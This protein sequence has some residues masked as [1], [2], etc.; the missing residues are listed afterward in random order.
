M[1]L[2]HTPRLTNRLGYTLNVTF[3]TLLHIPY[4]ITDDSEYFAKYEGPKMA[5]GTTPIGDAPFLRA[6]SLLFETSVSRFDIKCITHLDTKALF[7]IDPPSLLPYD[8]LAAIFFMLSRYEEYLPFQPDQHGRFPASQ[9]VAYQHQ[10]LHTA[11]V[12]RWALQ[13]HKALLLHFPDLPSPSRHAEFPITIDVDAAYCYRHKGLI[14]TLRGFTLDLLLRRSR[15]NFMHRLRVLLNK[16]N[17]PYDNFDYILAQTRQHLSTPAVFFILLGDYSNFDKPIAFTN[18]SFR[19]LIQY[20]GD[21]AKMAI[22]PSYYA[23]EQ[24]ELIAKETQ[25]LSNI[26]HRTIVRSRFHFLR[27]SLPNSYQNLIDNNILHD[28][29]MGYPND[30]GYRAG[31]G[32]PYPFFDLSTNQEQQLT[33]HPFIA[34]DTTLNTHMHLSSDEAEQYLNQLIH[35][36]ILNQGTLSTLWHNQNLSDSDQWAGWRSIFEHLLLSAEQAKNT[37]F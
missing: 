26:L 4:L 34:M 8:P 22:H 12:D 1:L 21:N 17:D 9:S 33:I 31:T 10:F 24:P 28:Y 6:A 11:V 27:F 13:L 36:N 3:K 7:P 15:A 23:L 30:I 18:R 29:S 37:S 14:R 19:Q 5:Y 2:V 35:E 16:E 20:L 32:T 25:R